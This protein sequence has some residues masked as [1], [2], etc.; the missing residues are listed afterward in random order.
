MI[1]L[2]KLPLS[3]DSIAQVMCQEENIVAL[4][5]SKIR[6]ATALVWEQR[7]GKKVPPRN[8]NKLSVVK[9]SPNKLPFK[10]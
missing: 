10:Q 8:T 5:L 4:D 6:C 3:M 2:V 1:I 9:H 7:Q